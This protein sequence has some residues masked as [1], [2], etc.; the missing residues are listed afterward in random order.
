MFI[1]KIK[2][3][4]NLFTYRPNLNR[5]RFTEYISNGI[6][7]VKQHTFVLFQKNKVV[8]PKFNLAEGAFKG[9]II[10]PEDELSDE[11]FEQ[12]LLEV[13]KKAEKLDENNFAIFL[14]DSHRV[15][16][17]NIALYDL[18]VSHP[19]IP[20]TNEVKS[21][22]KAIRDHLLV[23]FINDTDNIDVKECYKILE[24][25]L[26]DPKLSKNS[27]VVKNLVQFVCV[28]NEYDAS[29]VLSILDKD[30]LLSNPGVSRY[31]RN[32]SEVN[33]RP[34]EKIESQQ[35]VFAKMELIINTLISEDFLESE[36]VKDAGHIIRKT[37]IREQNLLWNEYYK[38]LEYLPFTSIQKKLRDTIGLADTPERAA[39]LLEGW[40]T[41]MRSLNMRKFYQ[42]YNVIKSTKNSEEAKIL[43][44]K[45]IIYS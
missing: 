27:N 1:P 2:L 35:E 33:I 43:K 18:V 9:K 16:K 28:H 3:S 20:N 7:N 10:R 42:L 31:F 6:G 13:R 39:V 44:L 24:K 4:H 34:T 41:L 15:N 38:A 14:L 37:K 5:T 23:S 26:S 25:V 32:N 11:I 17:D 22:D 30:V 45:E 21:Y 40:K 36:A 29:L 19:G 8:E 12:K